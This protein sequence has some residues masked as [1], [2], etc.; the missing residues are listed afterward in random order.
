[1]LEGIR[2]PALQQPPAQA[3]A[4]GEHARDTAGKPRRAVP[5]RSHQQSERETYQLQRLHQAFFQPF[6]VGADYLR[7]PPGLPPRGA[8]AVAEHRAFRGRGLCRRAPYQARGADTRAVVHLRGAGV[9]G[10][11]GLVAKRLPRADG[12]EVREASLWLEQPQGGALHTDVALS[13]PVALQLWN[14]GERRGA[15]SLVFPLLG[16]PLAR[17]RL[18]S[19][20]DA[21]GLEAEKPNGE[22]RPA[23]RR[24]EGAPHPRATHSCASQH[25]AAHRRSVAKIPRAATERPA[26]NLQGRERVGESLLRPL[27]YLRR[28]RTFAGEDGELQPDARLLGR[29]ALRSRRE[30]VAWGYSLGNGTG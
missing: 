1:M 10:A 18:Q 28:Q 2:P 24:G 14:R 13:P 30:T 16:R 15:V 5:G 11:R 9:A 25:Y 12:A 19:A 17:E 23:L 27:L 6:G 7:R 20:P 4:G 21:R 3:D 22:V 29:V 26:A 8:A